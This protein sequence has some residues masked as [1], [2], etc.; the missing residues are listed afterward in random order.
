M[1]RWRASHSLRLSSV[2][3]PRNATDLRGSPMV[4]GS[5]AR[6]GT[7]HGICR[8]EP[9]LVSKDH[10]TSLHH[11]RMSDV[12]RR[13]DTVHRIALILSPSTW[14]HP[15][16]LFLTVSTE[17]NHSAFPINSRS[18]CVVVGLADL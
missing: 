10:C 2:C 1:H 6:Q 9:E 11:R 16:I 4:L 15:I 8:R 5:R 7:G 3:D 17:N 13:R 14:P 18:R 12:E